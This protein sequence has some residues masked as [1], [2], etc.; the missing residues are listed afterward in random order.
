MRRYKRSLEHAVAPGVIH[1]SRAHTYRRPGN[2]DVILFLHALRVNLYQALG[3]R[4]NKVSP[5]LLE[6]SLVLRTCRKSAPRTL[7][8]ARSPFAPRP[9]VLCFE[10]LTPCFIVPPS[11]GFL[12]RRLLLYV[13]SFFSS[14]FSL[15]LFSATIERR[16]LTKIDQRKIRPTREESVAT[17]QFRFFF[18]PETGNS[19]AGYYPRY[20]LS[21]DRQRER[22]RFVVSRVVRI[23]HPETRMNIVVQGSK[24][25][26]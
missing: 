4:C 17:V 8:I 26:G 5:L 23:Y 21:F 18:H 2:Y 7:W 11:P 24:L 22:R 14:P 10:K 3:T 25:K 12:Q 19:Q 13:F 6:F 15:F 9:F 1:V 20:T 16:S